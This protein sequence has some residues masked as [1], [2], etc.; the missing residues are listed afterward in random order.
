MKPGQSVR[1]AC[2]DCQAVFDLCIAPESEWAEL[3]N[4]QGPLDIAV[5][6]C[7]FCG[8]SNITVHGQRIGVR[9]FTDG[10]RPVY[11]DVDGRQFVLDGNEKVYGSW[12]LD[13]DGADTPLTLPCIKP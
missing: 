2:G 1:F 5:T 4:D 7:P 9:T 6:A 12:I 11:I 8:E 10:E 3:P 13:D